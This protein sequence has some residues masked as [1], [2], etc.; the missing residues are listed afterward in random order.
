VAAKTIARGEAWKASV[1][2]NYARAALAEVHALVAPEAAA[3]ASD[4]LPA[5]PAEQM[6]LV[7]ALADRMEALTAP[8]TAR[9]G[10]APVEVIPAARRFFALCEAMI[11]IE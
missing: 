3:P 9:G 4:P 7:R 8:I 10:Q 11:P 2:L 1:I 5:Q 6:A